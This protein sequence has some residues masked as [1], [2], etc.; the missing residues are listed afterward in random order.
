M[1]ARGFEAEVGR[2][3]RANK[4][5]ASKDDCGSAHRGL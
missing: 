5:E 2:M 3:P 1:R 4:E